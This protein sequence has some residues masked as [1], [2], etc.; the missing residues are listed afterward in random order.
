MLEGN[1]L[2]NMNTAD[3]NGT[4]LTTTI[5]AG[6][7]QGTTGTATGN[8]SFP[9]TNTNTGLTIESSGSDRLDGVTLYGSGSP[10][11][12]NSTHRRLACNHTTVGLNW[13]ELAIPATCSAATVAGWITINPTN[14]SPVGVLYDY[15][16]ILNVTG[17]NTIFQLNSGSGPG[18]AYAVNIESD[19]SGTVHSSYITVVSGTRYWFSL[20]VDFAAGTNSLSLYD[21][22]GT[23]IQ[24]VTST[25]NTGGTTTVSKIRIGNAEIGTSAAT[26]YFENLIIDYMVAPTT[27]APTSSALVC[28]KKYGTSATAAGSATTIACTVPNVAEGDGIWVVGK[29]E[30]TTTTA[31]CSD[32]TTSLTQSSVGVQN[33]GG[34]NGEPHCVMFYLLSSVAT[35]SVTYTITLGAAKTFRECHAFA[36]TAPSGSGAA[37]LNGTATSNS[38]TSGTAITS[39]NIT[40]TGSN[41]IAASC[42]TTFGQA[43]TEF[44]INGVR[45][46]VAKGVDGSCLWVS[47]FTSGYTGGGS[48]TG[49]ATNRWDSQII[50]SDASVSGQP[51]LVRCRNVPHISRPGMGRIVGALN[52]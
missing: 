35:G 34:A 7:T 46:V 14:V 25:A 42:A 45:S 27:I 29:F 44:K 17:H 47:P 1:C 26:T 28:T 31:T 30:G 22:A 39:G 2:I 18:N 43:F 24:T 38:A 16:S 3:A 48:C 6:G 40:T 8:W 23:L 4:A 12:A 21:T 37:S 5:T 49:S 52:N 32:G 11:A 41:G 15:I 51:S 10:F 50:A 20:S 33:N 36:V 9:G 19:A 13:A